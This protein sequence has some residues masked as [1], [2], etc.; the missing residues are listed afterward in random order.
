MAGKM[1]NGYHNDNSYLPRQSRAFCEGMEYRAGGTELERPDTDNP[2]KTKS[3][4]GDCWHKGWEI[5]NAAG[6]GALS[7]SDFPCCAI[8]THTIEV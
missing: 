3:P 1:C 7:Q 5:T 2:H 4:D 6:G 8:P